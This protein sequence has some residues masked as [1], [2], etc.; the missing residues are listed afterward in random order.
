MVSLRSSKATKKQVE[1]RDEM[2]EKLRTG[3]LKA[4]RIKGYGCSGQQIR[5]WRTMLLR[6]ASKRA[7]F[8]CFLGLDE[9][10]LKGDSWRTHTAVR[11]P[12]PLLGEKR[13]WAW[14]Q[15]W[16]VFLL[17]YVLAAW[18]A[19]RWDCLTAR[20]T[21]AVAVIAIL[22]RFSSYEYT[23]TNTAAWFHRILLQR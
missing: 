13:C 14:C 22:Q 18:H 21:R 17:P 19:N 7:P 15:G 23:V 10:R 8:G 12:K 20:L 6:R 2:V 11:R 3:L 9:M 16:M 5:P 1:R 4:D